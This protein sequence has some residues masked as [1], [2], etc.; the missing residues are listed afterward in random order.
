MNKIII[1]IHIMKYNVKGFIIII[2]VK[3]F[4]DLS[5]R[6]LL[7]GSGIFLVVF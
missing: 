4:K 5:E 2:T 3:L 1:K 7:F 6:G